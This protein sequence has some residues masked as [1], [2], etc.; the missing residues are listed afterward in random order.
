MVSASQRDALDVKQSGMVLLPHHPFFDSVT[1]RTHHDTHDDNTTQHNTRH[2]THDDDSHFEFTNRTTHS[3]AHSS[4][5]PDAHARATNTRARTIHFHTA[6]ANHPHIGRRG[7]F[8]AHRHALSSRIPFVLPPPANSDTRR[9]GARSE[10][11]TRRR[12]PAVT[13][14][15]RQQG[16]KSSG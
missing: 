13:R 3:P 12:T 8:V 15:I 4:F 1:T 7:A 6:V 2:D 14:K 16:S 11:A 10:R 9:E 5:S